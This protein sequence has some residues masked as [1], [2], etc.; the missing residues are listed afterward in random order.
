MPDPETTA[1]DLEISITL[2]RRLRS[3]EHDQ[4]K[5]IRILLIQ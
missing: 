1:E 4:A 3:K 2:S 5:Q